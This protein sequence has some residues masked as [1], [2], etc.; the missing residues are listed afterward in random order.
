MMKKAEWWT[1]VDK[2]KAHVTLDIFVHNIAI[3]SYCEIDHFEPS[4]NS[5]DAG[6]LLSKQCKAPY[7]MIT[8]FPG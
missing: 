6:E 2:I 4:W 8:T 3:K 1:V 5:I 7:V